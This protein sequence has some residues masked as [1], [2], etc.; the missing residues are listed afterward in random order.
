VAEQRNRGGLTVGWRLMR[1]Q[2]ADNPS[3]VI[4]LFIAVFLGVFVLAITP[5]L[6]EKTSND[7]LHE[8]LA[9]PPVAQRNISVQT[10]TVISA[11]TLD[12]PFAR[13]ERAGELFAEEEMPDSVRSI[14]VDQRYV[15]DSPEFSVMPLPGEVEGPFPTF[16]RFRYQ[17]G[18]DE[19]AT[20]T[21]GALPVPREPVPILIGEGCPEDAGEREELWEALG[22]AAD[23]EVDCSIVDVPVFEVALTTETLSVLDF[24]VGDMVMLAPDATDPLFFGIGSNQLDYPLVLSVSGIIELSDGG[25]DYWYG[26]PGLHRASIT[27]NADFRIIHATGLMA[28]DDYRR[29][30]TETSP[31]HWRYS[32]RYFVDPDLV[33]AATV[34]ELNA[35]L[36]GLEL[37]FRS[38]GTPS[39][40]YSVI[41]LLP[42]LIDQ[43]SA[44]RATTVALM[45]MALSGVF[46]VAI[47][48]IL[49]LAG[50]VAVRQRRPVVLIRSRGSSRGQL[51]LTRVYQAFI[52]VV[53]AAILGYL[54]AERILPDTAYIYSYRGAVAFAAVAAIA[55]VLASVPLMFRPLG[56][57]QR[58][59]DVHRA[60][61]G[62][63][64]VFE[65]LVVVVAAGS[66]VLLRRRG[67][68][69]PLTQ[70]DMVFDPLLAVAPAL[71]GIAIG[72]VTLRLFP[73]LMRAIARALA[74]LRGPI[75]FIGFRRTTQQPPVSRVPLV[76]I[77][78]A[79]SIAVFSSVVRVSIAVSAADSAWQTVGADYRITGSGPG[80]DLP[81]AVD[82]SAIES[83]EASATAT[84]YPDARLLVDN[85]FGFVD[86]LAIDSNA[87]VN[88]VGGTPG[89]PAL[90]GFMLAETQPADGT[91]AGPIPVIVSSVGWPQGGVPAL[92]STWTL[93]IGRLDPVVIV[94]E[95]R[96][97]FP[98]LPTDRP[99]VVSDIR[100]IARM[101]Q[102]LDVR[103]TILYLKAVESSG[104]EIS[105]TI[106]AQ[107]VG[108]RFT[109]R[110]E[111][112]AEVADSTLAGA[113]NR[114]LMLVL[115]LC[116]IF[117]IVAAVSS[118][119]LSSDVRRRDFGYL[120][121]MGLHT[122]QATGL[123]VI[124]QIPQLMVAT[125]VGALLGVAM[126]I[127]LRPAIELEAFTGGATTAVITH[128]WPAVLGVATVLLAVL[129][130]AVVIFVTFN[131][132]DDLGKLLRVGDE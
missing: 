40:D 131:R 21:E 126:V 81:T 51:A 34:D 48:L 78:L 123:T 73:Y 84:R 98:G 70:S 22:S 121:T 95:I 28:S 57:L 58:T 61:S 117:A 130:L 132:D 85:P 119:A 14:I 104:I 3:V 7:A 4:T 120:R 66:I 83:I 36:R 44:A 68:I 64:L 46:T 62:G 27:E 103:P 67:A 113:V 71:L 54:V 6:F 108:A 31:A 90:P 37:E 72:L 30:L 20:L 101:S 13:V 92:G 88:V 76:V 91:E 116:T 33:D 23:I 56:S 99:F 96:D 2:L 93:D 74:G 16:V 75:A 26:D 94:A 65:L 42:S 29:L 112:L 55:F 32:W 41:T 9:G 25:L 86:F 24:G 100:P 8:S 53:P 35:D 111:T 59:L 107:T 97:R 110:Y 128:S 127:V 11:T 15:A 43:Y 80:T 118:L 114:G 60:G 50:L 5:R 12:F 129:A 49:E 115:I 39:D 1:K 82:V 102:P 47:A 69:D 106:D 77:L 79:V 105:S 18:I 124:E 87:Y 63:R 125:V 89:D 38:V 45:S 52:L 109:S 10:A 19:H 17:E 122:R